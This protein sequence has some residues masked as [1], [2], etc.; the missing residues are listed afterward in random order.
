MMW[1]LH[2]QDHWQRHKDEVQK[3][4][5]DHW[6]QHLRQAGEQN[7][8]MPTAKGASNSIQLESTPYPVDG[9]MLP[10]QEGTH[11]W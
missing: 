7:C 4:W 2:H 6:A 8:G 11:P 5:E 3:E 9:Q 10:K 1:D